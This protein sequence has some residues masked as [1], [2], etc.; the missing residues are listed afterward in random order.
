MVPCQIYFPTGQFSRELKFQ[1]TNFTRYTLVLCSC[2]S[3]RSRF[4]REPFSQGNQNPLRF[5]DKLQGTFLFPVN[6]FPRTV[7]LRN[8]VGD[9]VPYGFKAFPQEFELQGNSQF[10]V[11]YVAGEVLGLLKMV[12]NRWWAQRLYIVFLSICFCQRMSV[13][14]QCLWNL[15]YCNQ[16]KAMLFSLISFETQTCIIICE[17]IV[18]IISTAIPC[19]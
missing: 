3:M 18:N 13:C 11:V 1:G 5:P 4:P 7:S 2:V 6:M 9:Q 8:T 19:I 14:Q 12:A 10:P 16:L 17:L 15:Y